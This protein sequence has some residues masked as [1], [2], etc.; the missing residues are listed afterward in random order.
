MRETEQSVVRVAESGSG[1]YS[2][3]VWAG[4]HLLS[5]DQPQTRGG[6][7]VGPSPYEYLSAGLGA[8]TAM[9]LRDYVQRHNW[10]LHRVV[11]EVSHSNAVAADGTS[12]V[13]QFHRTIHL[14]G[15]LTAEQK[16][17]LLQ[18]AERSPV[19]E[20]LRHSSVVESRLADVP[21]PVP[22]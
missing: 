4:R 10:G 1:P 21:L 11:I 20:T 17:T 6:H 12:T 16:L 8:C 22:T 13:D 3:L 5:A 7:D 9:T 14:D 19:S 18:I 2:Q 15:D